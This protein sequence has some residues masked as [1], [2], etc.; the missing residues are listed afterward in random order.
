MKRILLTIEVDDVDNGTPGEVA[1]EIISTLAYIESKRHDKF[2][3]SVYSCHSEEVKE[4][5][6]K[7]TLCCPNT[8]NL[9]KEEWD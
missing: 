5:C 9:K 2:R 8:A 3:F 6:S 1:D 7:Q 4:M